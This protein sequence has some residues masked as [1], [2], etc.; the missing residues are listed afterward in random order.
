MKT[1]LVALT[2][3][4]GIHS[5]EVQGQTLDQ[6][7]RILDATQEVAST[8][9]ALCHSRLESEIALKAF[10]EASHPG[11][12]R[13]SDVDKDKAACAKMADDKVRKGLLEIRP[14]IGNRPA[15]LATLKE[16]YSRFDATLHRIDGIAPI[17][18]DIKEME[19]Y[20]SKAKLELAF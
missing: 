5:G 18:A 13:R 1:I 12:E 20:I 6:I 19:R 16:W 7:A 3:A 11:D 15:V 2:I 17:D 9:L 4:F 8:N 14:I 10:L